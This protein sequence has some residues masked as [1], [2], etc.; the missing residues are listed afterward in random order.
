M[1]FW[2]IVWGEQQT[3]TEGHVKSYL[4]Q[5]LYGV[6]YMHTNKILHRDIKGE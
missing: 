6:A 1:H 4:K 2:S 5:L 3:L